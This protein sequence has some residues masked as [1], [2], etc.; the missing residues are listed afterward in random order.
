MVI[1]DKDLKRLLAALIH[2]NQT[3]VQLSADLTT[4]Q[5]ATYVE[6]KNIRDTLANHIA[7]S[8]AEHKKINDELI[9]LKNANNSVS[10]DDS[11]F[12]SWTNF[13]SGNKSDDSIG[14]YSTFINGAHHL[15]LEMKNT[16]SSLS[17][18]RAYFTPPASWTN[19]KYYIDIYYITPD[20]S[21]GTISFGI[22]I[23]T[24]TMNS[25]I[26][27]NVLGQ[28]GSYVSLSPV[29]KN[30]SAGWRPLQ[31]FRYSLD[32]NFAGVTL[33]TV[34][35]GRY[36]TQNEP[37]SDTYYNSVYVLGVKISKA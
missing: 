29:A 15:I 22:G 11:V 36:M 20:D 6:T 13:L 28:P 17:T 23:R 5:S 34:Q 10:T 32:Q 18:S 30:T 7:A 27:D 14:P 3:I 31:R 33:A 16:K 21:D 8:D 35:I 37:N 4:L 9:S 2:K 19:Q 25:D 24:Y 1:L 26:A 12:I